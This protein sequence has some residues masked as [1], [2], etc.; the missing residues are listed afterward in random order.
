MAPCSDC[1]LIDRLQEP[2]DG[3]QR[4]RARALVNA[5]AESSPALV[6]PGV[7][8]DSLD[9]CLGVLRSYRRVHCQGPVSGPSGPGQGQGPRHSGGNAD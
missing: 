8:L 1:R 5:I 3:W 2:L 9:G 6:P 7:K 4:W